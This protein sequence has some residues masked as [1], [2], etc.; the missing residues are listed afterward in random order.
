MRTRF[1]VVAPR[2]VGS[3]SGNAGELRF[4]WPLADMVAWGPSLTDRRSADGGLTVG[5]VLSVAGG[6]WNEWRRGCGCG[7][8]RPISC[9]CSRATNSGV[10]LRT[11]FIA[12]ANSVRSKSQIV[13]GRTKFCALQTRKWRSNCFASQHERWHSPSARKHSWQW[14]STP[15]A[16]RQLRT[17]HTRSTSN[18][19]QHSRAWSS[20]ARRAASSRGVGASACEGGDGCCTWCC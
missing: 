1:V 8:G 5:C 6:C 20:S 2:G 19:V 11:C 17:P 7:C 3:V 4:W 9:G 16:T 12:H 13:H 10:T 18:G 15:R 14:S